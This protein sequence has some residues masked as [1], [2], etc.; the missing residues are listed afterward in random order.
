M[1]VLSEAGTANPWQAPGIPPLT[2]GV[3]MGP[4][5]LTFISVLC[6]C[7]WGYFS[8]FVFLRSLSC[9]PNVASVTGLSLF[10]APSVLSNGNI[11]RKVEDMGNLITAIRTPL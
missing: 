9:M 7:V 1:G 2:P 5:L 6:W 3:L 8:M 4:V 10:I 11:K